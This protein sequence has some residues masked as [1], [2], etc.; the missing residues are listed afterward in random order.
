[1]GGACTITRLR[2]FRK[3]FDIDLLPWEKLHFAGSMFLKALFVENVS[4]N[5][6][7]RLR[8]ERREL[9]AMKA[10]HMS[11]QIQTFGTQ[12]QINHHLVPFSRSF[13]TRKR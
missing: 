11:S 9:C 8:F 2:Q 4:A 13:R 12:E 7:A 10:H 1:V 3:P 5:T 6:M